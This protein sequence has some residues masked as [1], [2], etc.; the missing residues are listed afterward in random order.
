MNSDG[1]GV[2]LDIGGTVNSFNLDQLYFKNNQVE[3]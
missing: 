3:E 2:F 1:L